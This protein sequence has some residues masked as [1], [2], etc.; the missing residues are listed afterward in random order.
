MLTGKN[1]SKFLTKDI[2]CKCKFKF[3]GKNVIQIK[4]GIIINVNKNNIYVKKI[5]F[6]ILQYVVVKMIN[7]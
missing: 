2:S 4:R 6:R 3:D 7:I 1:E 5:I